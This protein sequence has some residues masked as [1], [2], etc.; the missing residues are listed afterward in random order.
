[1][2]TET[3]VPTE[4]NPLPS[5]AEKTIAIV[6]GTAATT[7]H[8]KLVHTLLSEEERLRVAEELKMVLGD[9]WPQ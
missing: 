3:M 6:E 9:E 7:P 4:E 1:M 5:M 2:S 8:T